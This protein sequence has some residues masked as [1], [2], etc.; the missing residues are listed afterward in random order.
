MKILLHCC[1]GPCAVYPVSRL[2]R[3]G[4]E[5]RAYFSNH[6]HPF[7]EWQKRL[8]TLQAWAAEN[9]LPVIVDERYELV[10]FLQQAVFRESRRCL[11]CYRDR[12]EKS[13]RL[14]QKSG[15][16]AFTTTL[17][18]SKFQ[19]HE[20]IRELGEELGRRYGIGFHYEDFRH[21]WKE[22]IAASKAAGM[23]RQQYCGCIYSEG[24]RYLGAKQMGY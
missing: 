22:G 3:Q 17:L 19:Q 2:R 5:L 12:L 6:I 14:A 20:T 16:E 13:A 7:T 1:C 9:D 23:Y 24:D 10:D 18:Y 11:F 4:H 8:E 21:G 15:F